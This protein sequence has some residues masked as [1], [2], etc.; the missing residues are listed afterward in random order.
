MFLGR[1]EELK[2][3]GAELKKSSAFII[4]YGTRRVGKTALIM[5]AL[6]KSPDKTIYY[7][8]S[9]GSFAYNAAKFTD[10]IEDA[11]VTFPDRDKT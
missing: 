7:E 3:I 8:C 6:K 9:T 5:E 2:K 10:K 11:G 1:E 4:V